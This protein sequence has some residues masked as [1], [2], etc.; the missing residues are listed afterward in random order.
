MPAETV[1]DE[2]KSV[3]RVSRDGGDYV[4]KCPHCG[5]VI[6]VEGDDLSDIQGG[7]YQHKN[8][9]RCNGWFEIT[10]NAR[11]VREV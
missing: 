1:T 3:S 11:L 8:N 5:W 9:G 6:G 2:I 4:V 10:R 7:Q